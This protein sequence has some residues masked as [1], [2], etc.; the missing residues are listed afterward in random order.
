[1]C[2]WVAPE[3]LAYSTQQCLHRDALVDKQPDV[4]FGLGQR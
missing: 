3:H 2:G 1:M 4:A